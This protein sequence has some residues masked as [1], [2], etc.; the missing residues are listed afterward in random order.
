MGIPRKS[1]ARPHFHVLP[2]QCKIR[3]FGLLCVPVEPTAQALRAE[4]AAMPFRALGCRRG[5]CTCFHAAPFHRMMRILVAI[6]LGSGVRC[7]RAGL[8]ADVGCLTA[9]AWW[10]GG[11]GGAL[12]GYGGAVAGGSQG[13]S[14]KSQVRA[15]RASMPHLAVVDR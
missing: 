11:G 15:S 13:P 6:Q 12:R 7:G 2:F 10:R 14:V 4:V 5:V 1:K 9:G 8:P 3:A